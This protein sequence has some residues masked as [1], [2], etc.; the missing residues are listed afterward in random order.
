MSDYANPRPDAISGIFVTTTQATRA[1]ERFDALMKRGWEK[2]FCRGLLLLGPA[3]CGKTMM[4]DHW[5]ERRS[6]QAA[7]AGKVFRSLVTDVPAGCNLKGM[8]TELLTQ[9]GDPDP[10]YGSQTDKTR[11]IYDLAR[12]LDL[13]VIDEIQRLLD[14]DTGRVKKD[15]ASWLTGLLSKR[16]C[17]LLLVGEQYATLVFHGNVYLTGRTLGQVPVEP[18]DWHDQDQRQEFRTF[19]SLV[20]AALGMPALSGLGETETALRIYVFSDGRIGMATLLID[21]ARSIAQAQGS[22]KLTWETMAAA[23]DNLRIG[24]SRTEANPF[25]TANAVAPKPQAPTP[26]L[27]LPKRLR[28]PGRPPKLQAA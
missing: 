16:I 20:D 8:A 24:T 27:E 18:Y 23:I 1:F 13:L 7:A 3:R 6:A 2:K 19:L 4:V 28:G 12:N 11:R 22:P 15:V 26:P 9:L 14:A 5:L 25:R 17:P 21:E 10:D